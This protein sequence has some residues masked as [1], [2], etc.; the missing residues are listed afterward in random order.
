MELANVWY[1]II[2]WLRNKKINFLVQRP[3]NY[4]IFLCPGHT[5]TDHL[6]GSTTDQIPRMTP[7]MIISVVRYR[8]TMQVL[9][10]MITDPIRKYT[11]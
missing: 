4:S 1:L 7:E 5:L 6:A 10:R 8:C 3:A 2:F 11:D 9:L